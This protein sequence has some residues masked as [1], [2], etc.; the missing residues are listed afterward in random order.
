MA[1]RSSGDKELDKRR[2]DEVDALTRSEDILLEDMLLEAIDD[3]VEA[4]S[5]AGDLTASERLK[6]IENATND[7]IKRIERTVEQ[8]VREFS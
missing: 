5:K 4:A 7:F 1:F 2:R 8:I 6:V 3:A